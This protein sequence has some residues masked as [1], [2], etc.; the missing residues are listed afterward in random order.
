MENSLLKSHLYVLKNNL[1]SSYWDYDISSNW[2]NVFL[3]MFD[4]S[5][6][7]INQELC[8]Y[9]ERNTTEKMPLLNFFLAMGKNN[10]NKGVNLKH[11]IKQL[12]DLGADPTITS[13]DEQL[14]SRDAFD[15][16]MESG[17]PELMELLLSHEKA[18][19]IN[20]ICSRSRQLMGRKVPI[21]CY[22]SHLGEHIPMIKFLKDKG[23]NINQTDSR[24]WNFMCWAKDS[25]TVGKI[26]EWLP[27]E[28][29]TASIVKISQAIDE[30]ILKGN[31]NDYNGPALIGEFKK[32]IKTDTKTDLILK[33]QSTIIDAMALSANPYTFKFPGCSIEELNEIWDI[34]HEIKKGAAKGSWNFLSA[35]ALCALSVRKSRW[36]SYSDK[37]FEE[38]KSGAWFKDTEKLLDFFKSKENIQEWLNEPIDGDKKTK[39]T[40]RFLLWLMSNDKGE[41]KKWLAK[42]Y[43]DT[44]E[45]KLTHLIASIPRLFKWKKSKWRDC[46]SSNVMTPLLMNVFNNE[47]ETKIN[48]MLLTVFSMNPNYKVE[49]TIVKDYV[50]KLITNI[51]NDELPHDEK[52][53]ACLC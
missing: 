21:T 1:E 35:M 51:L 40:N 26:K 33:T 16:A 17:Q 46:M 28:V 50:K 32:I 37:Y 13:L 42:D 53:I 12:L 5:K 41:F 39:L 7:D 48:S 52:K 19:N 45:K 8:N 24:D 15:F 31:L 3:N 18:P 11:E 44:E 9:K 38:R 6:F 49:C 20:E 10:L 2:F 34:K 30:R 29:E 4:L 43:L 23:G 22:L 36:N 27:E 47:P 14:E 25:Y